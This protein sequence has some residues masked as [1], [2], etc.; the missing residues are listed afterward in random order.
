[1]AR[2]KTSVVTGALTG[3]LAGLV[4]AY[5][6]DRFQKAL[7]ALSDLPGEDGDPS[8]VKVAAMVVVHPIPKEDKPTAGAIVHYGFGMALGAV[9]GAAAAIVPAMASGFGMVYGVTVALV[10]DEGAL[11]SLGIAEPPREANPATHAYSLSSHLV[12]GAAL[13]GVR[14]ILSH[15][16]R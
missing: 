16:F 1:M 15:A 14:R 3:A 10:V 2:A 11:P 5:A 12:Y 9:Y 4:A 13:E 8:T 7:S 6:M